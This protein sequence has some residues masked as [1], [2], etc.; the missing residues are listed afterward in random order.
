MQTLLQSTINP[1]LTKNDP[2][3]VAYHLGWYCGY[4][5][6]GFYPDGTQEEQKQAAHADMLSMVGDPD[7]RTAFLNAWALGYQCAMKKASGRQ[8]PAMACPCY[9]QQTESLSEATVI[10]APQSS[11]IRRC[12]CGHLL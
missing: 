11:H 6:Y 3:A 1:S 12:A 4:S 7:H 5:F 10:V 9:G 2:Q 8:L